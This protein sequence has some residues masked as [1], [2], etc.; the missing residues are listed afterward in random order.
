MIVYIEDLIIDLNSYVKVNSF[1]SNIVVSFSNQ[2]FSGRGFTEKQ[3]LLAVKLLKKYCNN[4]EIA[5]KKTIAPEL[6]NPQFRFAIRKTSNL[7]SRRV[8][9]TTCP[10]WGKIIKVE[11]PYSEEKVAEIRKHRDQLGLATWDGDAKAWNFSLSETNLKFVQNLTS[12]EPFEYDDEFTDY[13][14]QVSDII[15]NMEKYVPMLMLEDNKVVFKNVSHYIPKIDGENILASVFAARKSGINT[16]DERINKILEEVNL[17]PLIKPFLDNNYDGIFEI[18]STT[19]PI[20]CLKD[21]VQH[22]N[23]CLFVIPGGSELEKTKMVYNFLTSLGY[24][25]NEMSV[26]FRLP[27]AEGKIFNDFVK[28]CGLNNPKTDITK[29]IFVSTKLPKPIL[30]SKMVFN[31]VVSLGRSNVHYTI[32]DFFKNRENL[33]YYC[34]PSKQKEFN[35]GIL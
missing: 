26:M 29:F 33:I 31:S 32:R 1:D 30:K 20:E 19:E 35:F 16:W 5:T 11:F 34:E 21:V 28:N 15:N 7:Q 13:L 17:H 25:S 12:K 4:L 9:I 18:D 6:M 8:S 10:Q 22:M 24:T 2:I 3:S 23:P 14:N 27:T